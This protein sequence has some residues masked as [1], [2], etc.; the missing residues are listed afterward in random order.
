MR[1]IDE[2]EERTDESD[3]DIFPLSALKNLRWLIDRVRRLE[4]AMKEIKETGVCSGSEREAY[5]KA[6]SICFCVA[7]NALEEGNDKKE[8]Q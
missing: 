4:E 5:I 3:G 6:W 2:I 7:H 1:R 8:T